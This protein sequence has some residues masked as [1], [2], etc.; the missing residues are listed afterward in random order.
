LNATQNRYQAAQWMGSSRD[1]H[2]FVQSKQE[3]SA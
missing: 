1:G 2:N 3:K